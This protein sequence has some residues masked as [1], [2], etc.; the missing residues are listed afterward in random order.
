MSGGFSLGHFGVLL[1]AQ[2]VDHLLLESRRSKD[3]GGIW[4]PDSV[5]DSDSHGERHDWVVLDII[6]PDLDRPV[7]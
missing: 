6:V 1:D 4:C 7:K 5:H 3:G 2:I